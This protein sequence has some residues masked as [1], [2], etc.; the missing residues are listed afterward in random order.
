MPGDARPTLIYD[1][2]CGIC[3]SAVRRLRA[4]DR[5]EQIDYV[6]FQDEARVA[7]FGIAL[8]ARTPKPIVDKLHAEIVR[9]L[10]SP[11]LQLRRCSHGCALAGG[12]S[13]H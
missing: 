3:Q 7:R 6:P 11:E 5:G 13:F 1:G 8:P 4:W 10:R 2:E 12:F 9:I